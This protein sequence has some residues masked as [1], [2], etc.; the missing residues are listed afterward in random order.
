[1][2][3]DKILPDELEALPA[4][5]PPHEFTGSGL[6]VIGEPTGKSGGE[7]HFRDGNCR[8]IQC[9]APPVLTTE[10]AK[11]RIPSLHKRVAWFIQA[12]ERASLQTPANPDDPEQ[13]RREVCDRREARLFAPE[14][15]DL[16]MA[17][18]DDIIAF[19]KRVE[20][21][22]E[23]IKKEQRESDSLRTKVDGYRSALLIVASQCH[24]PGEVTVSA[25]VD[26]L[27][28]NPEFCRQ[29]Q[30]VG[31]MKDQRGVR[32]GLREIGFDWMPAGRGRGGSRSPHS[33]K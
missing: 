17:A 9:A 22:I 2:E 20:R 18:D 30:I 28:D 23:A 12:R 24:H 25:V 27:R 14:I 15:A 1:M 8:N 6:E 13:Q 16:L 11:R 5:K 32:A 31:T 4:T 21:A 19:S 7:L 10:E 33:A 26:Y 29:Y 3:R